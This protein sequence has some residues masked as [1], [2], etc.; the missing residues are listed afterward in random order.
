MASRKVPPANNSN[1]AANRYAQ[2]SAQEQLIANKKRELEQKLLAQ[3]MQEQQDTL[4]KM[5]KHDKN[6]AKPQTKFLT[7]RGWVN[8]KLWL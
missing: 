3:K 6:A 5:K 7:S 2:M 1:N 4:T 8:H